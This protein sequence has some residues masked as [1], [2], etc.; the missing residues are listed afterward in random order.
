VT[1]W[2]SLMIG[3]EVILRT[4]LSALMIGFLVVVAV[5]AFAIVIENRKTR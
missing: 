4:C 5:I 3:G 2:A 1:L